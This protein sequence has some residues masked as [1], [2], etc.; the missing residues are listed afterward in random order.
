MRALVHPALVRA[1]RSESNPP[2]KIPIAEEPEYPSYISYFLNSDSSSPR[3]NSL[4]AAFSKS[5]SEGRADC[6]DSHAI[7]IQFFESRY[8]TLVQWSMGPPKM[9]NVTAMYDADAGT[10]PA[11]ES[12]SSLGEEIDSHSD[13]GR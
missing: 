1:T 5:D 2:A 9:H 3:S 8:C 4:V 12:V 11:A 13:R 7:L 6:P 10:Q